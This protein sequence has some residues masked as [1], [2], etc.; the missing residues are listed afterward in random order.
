MLI[1]VLT[2]RFREGGIKK[3]VVFESVVF[4]GIIL[5]SLWSYPRDHH[6]SI[7]THTFSFMGSFESKHNPEW[8]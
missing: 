7:M 3:Y 8:W 4:W 6:Y 2:G 1:D 5:M